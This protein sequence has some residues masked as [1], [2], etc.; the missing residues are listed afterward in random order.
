MQLAGWIP[1]RRV[2][3]H[4]TDPSRRTVARWS[5]APD[6][7]DSD[8]SSPV[9]LAS[10]IGRGAD[11][12]GKSRGGV[13]CARLISTMARGTGALC[14]QPPPGP[15]G[16][17]AGSGSGRTR[18]SRRHRSPPAPRT[19]GTAPPR[20][21]RSRRPRPRPVAGRVRG[22]E[23]SSP[24]DTLARASFA[25]SR[26]STTAAGSPRAP[27]PAPRH[28]VIRPAPA[29][30]A[31]VWLARCAG[32]SGWLRARRRRVEPRSSRDRSV[33]CAGRARRRHNGPDTPPSVVDG[34][35]RSRRPACCRRRSHRRH[36]N[37]GQ[38]AGQP[39]LGRVSAMRKRW[40]EGEPRAL[41]R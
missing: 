35:N 22:R 32:R 7:V 33:H 10:R 18:R 8:R 24:M 16:G 41:R 11:Q 37:L 31:S 2:R 15:D 12:P 28:T 21:P 9:S 34:T 19:P 25:P 30:A 20:S 14:S 5:I 36:R 1:V 38:P 40:S 3:P 23:R 17:G 13:S 29:L 39:A 6:V 4:R 26:R 27:S